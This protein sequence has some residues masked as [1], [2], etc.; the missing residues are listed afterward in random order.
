MIFMLVKWQFVKH[1]ISLLNV[2]AL[3]PDMVSSKSFLTKIFVTTILPT[4]ELMG[5]NSRTSVL[6]LPPQEEIEKSNWCFY[7]HDFSTFFDAP[8]IAKKSGFILYYDFWFLC[9]R[10]VESLFG[11]LG[12]LSHWCVK[13]L[14]LF[15]SYRI[16]GGSQQTREAGWHSTWGGCGRLHESELWNFLHFLKL[17]QKRI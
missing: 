17:L 5:A 15:C 8:K 12:S 11:H 3:V 10:G 16:D 6:F 4:C 2:K 14:I 13:Q 9:E 7:A 1:L